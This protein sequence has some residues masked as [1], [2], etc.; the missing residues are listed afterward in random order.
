M[1]FEMSAL[2]TSYF[3]S[4]FFRMRANT[5]WV[6]I[7]LFLQVQWVYGQAD[8]IKQVKADTLIQIA[9]DTL[10]SDLQEGGLSVEALSY[11]NSGLDFFQIN[12]L[13]SAKHYFSL[14]L[15]EEDSFPKAL[16]NRAAVNIQLAEHREAIEDLNRYTTLVDTATNA[17]FF[18]AR[19]YDYLGETDSALVAYA[20]AIS[21]KAF[22]EDSH[23]R[24]AE[25]LRQ[26]GNYSE[27]V[28]DFSKALLENSQNAKALHDR[29]SCKKLLGQTEAAAEDYRLAIKV[30]PKMTSAYINLGSVYRNMDMNAEALAEFNQ[31]LRLD[32][33]NILALNNRGNT[34]FALGNYLEAERDFRKVIQ[35][36]PNYAYAHNNLAGAL[37]KQERYDEAIN[38]ASRAI[39]LDPNYGFAFL[40][41]GIA[42]EMVRDIPGACSDW[43]TAQEMGIK[44]ADVYQNGPCNY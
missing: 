15:A 42:R 36:D 18:K 22:L 35:F 16:I 31:A 28:E 10:S 37:I 8:T 1:S 3:T 20:Q 32:D 9:A 14:A 17:Y 5:L 19:S 26:G 41:R 27:A 6:M 2:S 21:R 24:R 4:N 30:D 12:Q 7:G 44:N 23:L 34:H 11:Y 39:E 38:S 33:D 25:I 29:A 40:N 43:K 13:D